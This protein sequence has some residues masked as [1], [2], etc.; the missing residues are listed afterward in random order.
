L[1]NIIVNKQNKLDKEYFPNDLRIVKVPFNIKGFHSK[2]LMRREAARNLENLFA[3]AYYD[4]LELYAISGFRPYERQEK[5]FAKAYQLDGEEANQYSARAGESEHQ[6]GLAM[7]ISCETMDYQL[8]EEFGETKE[9]IWLRENAYKFGYILRYPKGKED[10]T[11]YM[12]EPWHIRYVGES[13][14]E[15]LYFENKVLEE[16]RQ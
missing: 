12:Y 14:A 15:K 3:K 7:D 8:R 5:I 13:L 1:Y 10:V 4:R 9:G 6:T 16:Y 11:G 2:R